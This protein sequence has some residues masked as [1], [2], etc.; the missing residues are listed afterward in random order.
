[1]LCQL[2]DFIEELDLEDK[3]A[4]DSYFCLVIPVCQSTNI[5]LQCTLVCRVH[6]P[7]KVASGRQEKVTFT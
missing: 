3:P 1:M 2:Q 4:D 5:V 6:A 7:N